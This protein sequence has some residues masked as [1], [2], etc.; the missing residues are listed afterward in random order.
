MAYKFI[1][2]SL[3][4]KRQGLRFLLNIMGTGRKPFFYFSITHNE[5]FW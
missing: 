1:F 4:R 2:W 5:H 3:S